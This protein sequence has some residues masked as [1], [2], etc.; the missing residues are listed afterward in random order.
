MGRY[1]FRPMRVR[2][3]AK[4]LFDSKRI[5]GLPQWYDI[6]GDIPPGETLARPVLRAPTPKRAKKPSRMFQ[7]LPIRY[8]EDK[9]RSEFFGDH[10]WELAKPRLIVEDSGNDAKGYDWSKI[11]QPGKQLDGE[12]VVQRQLWLMNNRSLSQ[13]AAYDVARREFY[14]HRHLEDIRRRVAK[15]EALHVG[16]Y[17]GKGP[18]EVG[19]ELEDRTWEN[20]KSW[21][22][23]QIEDEEAQRAQ[24]FSGPQTE[25]EISET[26]FDAAI[27][28]ESVPLAKGAPPL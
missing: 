15:E 18:L 1:D 23:K 3:T 8:P 14:K 4:A 24:M 21:A 22:S 16:A 19:M 12:S 28:E 20:W 17:F 7:P 9:L 10:P 13:A 11:V 2:Q 6:V 27:E 25:T 26:D 5:P